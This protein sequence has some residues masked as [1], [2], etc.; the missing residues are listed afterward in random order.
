MKSV[1]VLDFP[2]NFMFPPIWYWWIERWFRIL[3]CNTLRIYCF[4]YSVCLNYMEVKWL[5]SW[6]IVRHLKTSWNKKWLCQWWQSWKIL[7]DSYI[8]YDNVIKQFQNINFDYILSSDLYRARKTVLYIKK[9]IW[10]TK[11]LKYSKYFREMNFWMKIIW[12]YKKITT[13]NI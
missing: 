12:K 13:R 3:S 6:S 8:I 10:F 1:L 2:S 9:Q 7:K 5:C 11:N 4:W